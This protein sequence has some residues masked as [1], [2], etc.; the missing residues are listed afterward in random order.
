MQIGQVLL[1]IKDLPQVTMTGSCDKSNAETE[2]YVMGH[3]M[4]TSLGVDEIKRIG[5]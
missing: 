2:F 4:L 1:V 3:G 5:V